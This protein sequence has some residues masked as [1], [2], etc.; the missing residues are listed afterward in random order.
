[1]HAKKQASVIVGEFEDACPCRLGR[2]DL[3]K[4]KSLL[5]PTGLR[6]G[7]ER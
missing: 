7:E 6:E 2:A 3:K 4:F 5:S 1:M